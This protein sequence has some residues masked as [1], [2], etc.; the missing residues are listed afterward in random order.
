MNYTSLSSPVVHKDINDIASRTSTSLKHIAG[1][2]IGITGANGFLASN[3]I[4][5]ILNLSSIFNLKIRVLAFCRS[6]QSLLSRFTCS[7]FSKFSP[8]FNLFLTII[9]MISLILP[10]LITSYM[11]QVTPP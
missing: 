1:S 7:D 6:Q 3:I 5:Y 9:T 11:L 2:T 8:F 10:M 4:Y